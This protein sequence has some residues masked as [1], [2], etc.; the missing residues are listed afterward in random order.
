MSARQSRRRSACVAPVQSTARDDGLAQ[1]ARLFNTAGDNA[2]SKRGRTTGSPCKPLKLLDPS[3]AA[4]SETPLDDLTLLS[5]AGNRPADD[6]N[7]QPVQWIQ[8]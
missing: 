5:H 1:P 4:M 6:I 8:K 7:P 3:G 2:T